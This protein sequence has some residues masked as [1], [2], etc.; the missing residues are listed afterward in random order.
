[1]VQE[2]LGW[3][4]GLSWTFVRYDAICQFRGWWEG[5]RLIYCTL[6]YH[7]WATVERFEDRF[8]KEGSK[9]VPDSRHAR[10]TVK[11]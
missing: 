6:I 5:Q 7:T 11:R 2:C 3:I 8:S 10:N 1:M 4:W 9:M